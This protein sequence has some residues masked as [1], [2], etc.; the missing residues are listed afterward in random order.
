MEMPKQAEKILK[1]I[2]GEKPLKAPITI[3]LD[4]EC[5]LAFLFRM[6]RMFKKRTIL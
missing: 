3:Y 5:L 1:Y 6:F 2:Q 4:L